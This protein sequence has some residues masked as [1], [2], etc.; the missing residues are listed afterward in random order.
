MGWDNK[1]GGFNRILRSWKTTDDPS[2]GDFST[3]LRTSGFPE[4]YIY[5]KESITY[6]S[7]P[8]LGN[9]F[10]SVPGMKPVDYIDNSF[11]EN[12][13]QVVYSYR[14][15]K[16]NIYS[17]LS[18]SSTGLLQRLTW[19]RQHRVGNSYGTHQ[20]TYVITT[21]SVGITVIAMRTLHLFVIVS[22]GLS[23]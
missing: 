4:F 2:S 16:T 14:V 6:R 19:M 15:N 21:K 20:R 17:I 5:N 10:S 3:K 1:S 11:T 8:W 18:L 13:Q 9:R 23:Q 22:K 12:N 7:G